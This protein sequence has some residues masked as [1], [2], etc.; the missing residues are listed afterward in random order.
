MTDIKPNRLLWIDILRG[1]AILFMVPA[2]LSTLWDASHPMWFRLVGSFAAPSFILLSTA[3]VCFNSGRHSLKYYIERG[4]MI[5]LVGMM[6]DMFLWKIMPFTSYDILYFIGLSLPIAYLFRNVPSKTLLLLTII[7]F[8]MAPVAQQI[9]GYHEKSL[10]IEMATFH[11]PA[12]GRVLQ[13]MFVDGWF[14]IIPWIGLSFFSIVL[15]RRL[16]NEKPLQMS[17]LF[18]IGGSISIVGFFFLFLPNHFFANIANGGIIE[19]R[20]GYSEIFYRPTIA[21]MVTAIGVFMLLICLAQFF[22][23]FKLTSAIGFFGK[24]SLFIYILH[25]VIGNKIISVYF[26]SKGEESITNGVEFFYAVCFTF[27]CIIICCQLI[28]FAKKFRRP[29]SAFLQMLIGK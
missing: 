3:M 26:Q 20:E 6:I 23:K 13:S 14:P 27:I 25:Q 18:L 2:N 5:L 10:E 22:A 1:L 8:I 11:L 16:F 19:N 12:F 29:Q 24:Y 17:H 21:F 15:F 7:F 28:E 9:F 4:I